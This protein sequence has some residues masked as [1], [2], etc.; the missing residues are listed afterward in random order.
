MIRGTIIWLS[1]AGGNPLDIPA[2]VVVIVYT[3]GNI[4]SKQLT[5]LFPLAAEDNAP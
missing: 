3:Q 4:P 1:K 2:A 5:E